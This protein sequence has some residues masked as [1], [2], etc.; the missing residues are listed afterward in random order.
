MVSSDLSTSE[1]HPYYANYI[2]ILGQV[3]LMSALKK[4]RAEFLDFV[5]TIPDDKLTCSYADGKWSIAAVLVHLVDAE[6]VFQYR[7]LR[8]ARNDKTPLPGF[9]QNGYSSE[10]YADKKSKD[11]LIQEFSTVRDATVVLFGTFGQNILKRTGVADNAPMSVGAVGFVICGH[12]AHHLAVIKER[13]LTGS[14]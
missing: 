10:S 4:G 1:Y 5:G 7:A 8:F 3:S 11:Q 2:K 12:Q 9:E 13:Y 6:R 14:S